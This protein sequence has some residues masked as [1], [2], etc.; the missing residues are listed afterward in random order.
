MRSIDFDAK[1]MP[2]GKEK[3][4]KLI[5]EYYPQV[6]ITIMPDKIEDFVK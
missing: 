6:K 1:I 2:D 4:T 5:E 3:I